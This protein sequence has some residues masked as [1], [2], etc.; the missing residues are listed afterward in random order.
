MV[1]WKAPGSIWKAP[2]VG[3]GGSGDDF[4]LSQAFSHV[5]SKTFPPPLPPM[6]FPILVEPKHP[7]KVKNLPKS[8]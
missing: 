1:S 3:F 4:R 2:G 5:A 7:K 6:I 8:C